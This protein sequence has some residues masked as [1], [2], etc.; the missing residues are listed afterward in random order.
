MSFRKRNNLIKEPELSIINSA[1]V[2]LRNRLW[3]AIELYFFNYISKTYFQSGGSNI[4]NVIVPIWHN[5]KKDLVSNIEYSPYDAQVQLRNYFFK[6]EWDYAFEII[7]S[8]INSSLDKNHMHEDF[9]S[10]INHVFESE[11]YGYRI[12]DG[13]VIQISNEIESESIKAVINNPKFEEPK[14]H[15]KKALLFISDRLNPDYS[16]SIKESISAVES[17]SR[18]ITNENTFNDAIN[19]LETMGLI[20]HKRIKEAI[21][22]LYAY[23]NDKSSGIRHAIIENHTPPKFED[24]Q[25]VLITCSAFIN[26]IYSKEAKIK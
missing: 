8:L 7:E 20:E 2:T 21:I 22:K 4:H 9:I 13:L 16:N 10:E 14:T 5:I 6:C 24:A 15:L 23:T 25:F 17:I 3:N 1:T 11:Y 18:I 26:Y 19:K 12:I